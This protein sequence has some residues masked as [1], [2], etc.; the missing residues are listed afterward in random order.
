MVSQSVSSGTPEESASINYNL[1]ARVDIHPPARYEQSNYAEIE[2]PYTFN[3]AVNCPDKDKWKIAIQEEL[4]S[5]RENSGWEIVD[6]PPDI[7]PLD[8]IWVFIKKKNSSGVV[9]MYKARLCAR[10]CNQQKGVDYDCTY[11]PT[12]KYEALR[13]LLELLFLFFLIV[14]HTK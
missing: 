12:S 8:A 4:D 5:Q 10:G 6:C 11:A 13:F 7:K 1:R 3:E 9:K 14:I 2:N